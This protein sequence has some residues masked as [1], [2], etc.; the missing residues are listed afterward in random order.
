MTYARVESLLSR[1]HYKQ[2]YTFVPL[3]LSAYQ[4]YSDYDV[5]VKPRGSDIVDALGVRMPYEDVRRPG[6]DIF[7][8]A[9]P[10]AQF[11]DAS[12]DVEIAEC[13]LKHLVYAEA[14][15]TQEQFRLDGAPVRDPH[16]MGDL[17]P[18]PMRIG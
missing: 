6:R 13:I 8:V 3:K 17:V 11:T 12:D 5:M 1:L 16:V 2:G 7:G 9:V 15:E 14:H 18:N 4:R 10:L